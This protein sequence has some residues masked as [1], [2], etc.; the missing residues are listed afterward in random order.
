MRS[1]PIGNTKIYRALVTTTA[2]SGAVS[3]SAIGPY[4]KMITP[5]I[6]RRPGDR[7]RVEIQRLIVDL[8]KPADDQLQWETVKE[9]TLED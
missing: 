3:Q 8:S 7:V 6:W 9:K 5:N 4:S 2:P 1:M